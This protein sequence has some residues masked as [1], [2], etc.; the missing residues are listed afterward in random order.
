MMASHGSMIH[1]VSH[2][3][4][5]LCV[6]SAFPA[7]STLATRW[8][9]TRSRFVLMPYGVHV[10]RVARSLPDWI[11]SLLKSSGST[12]VMDTTL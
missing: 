2:G 7:C 9:V 11:S 5:G 10:S 3:Q 4:F 1:A 12:V 8:P 6:S